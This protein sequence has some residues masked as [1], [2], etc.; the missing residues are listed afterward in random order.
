[1]TA[2]AATAPRRTAF[3]AL[4]ELPRR[5]AEG[6]LTVLATMAMVAVF[7]WSLI[8]ADWTPGK[9]G[10]SNFLP[11]VGMAGLAFGVLG[12]KVGWGRWRTHL[13]GALFGGIFI[14]LVV[15][16]IVV[17]TADWDIASLGARFEASANVVRL[18]YNDWVVLN[19]PFTSQT[20]HYHLIFG[21]LVWGAGM[22]AGFTIFGHHRPLDAVVVLG[23]AV[24][25]NM[26][27]TEH[28]QLYLMVIFTAAAL[29]VLIRT[30]VFEE[31]IT[32]ARR[33]IGDPATVGQLY[34]TGG[35]LFVVGAIVGSILLTLTASSAPLQGLWQDLPHSLQALSQALQK[36]APEGGDIRGLGVVGFGDNVT[37][38]GIWQ[39][40]D[41]TAFRAQLLT[42]VTAGQTFK[43]RAGT[44]AIYT[45]Y[46]WKWG[47]TRVEPTAAGGVLLGGDAAGDAP[48]TATRKEVT[49]RIT[50]DAF[51]DSTILG[52]NT[53]YTVNRPTNALVVGTGYFATVQATDGVGAYNVTARI[54]TF[55]DLPGGLTTPR[56]RLAGTD[57]PPGLLALYTA[58]PSGAMGP[59]AIKLLDTIRAQVHAPSYADPGN[60]YD[61]AHTMEGYLQSST[62]FQYDTNVVSER[63]AQCGSVSTVECFAIIHRGYCEY[64]AST[65][66]VL[67]RAF[68]VPARVAYGFLPVKPG[69]D[70][71]EVIQAKEAHWWVEVYFPG[72]GWV[73]FDPT[74]GGVGQPL[75]IPSGAIPSATPKVSHAPTTAGP[76]PSFPSGG[77]AGGVTPTSTGAGPFIAIALILLLGIGALAFAALRR[78][79]N[80]PMHPDKAWGSLASLA[81]RFGL[82]PKPSQTVYEYAGA[83]GDAVPGARVELTTIA[84]AKVEVAYG[85]RDLGVD[86]LKR[87]AEAYQRLRFAIL[88]VVVRRILRR[89]GRR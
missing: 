48:D 61:L 41:N 62:N 88:G 13:V 69:P 64:Y 39:P 20:A 54:P 81:T 24:I 78:A 16:G 53:L 52:P 8:D 2:I 34:L 25:A 5:P 46:G 51:R 23:L 33:K 44:Y 50:P 58:L 82:G 40:S 26:A 67:L 70:G 10:D 86:R 9:P 73:E 27:L 29:L 66:A 30:H 4:R 43:W 38:S 42:G 49:F 83:L 28:N 84:R 35:A 55:A 21:T 89:G 18:V 1:M 57:Y 7:G 72:T 68:G 17:P 74:G 79:P 80:K 87:I 45:D 76:G 77:G 59:N 12:A 56:L 14:P 3:D 15:G 6:W 71:V 36:F 63:N 22:L 19:L 11:W 47:D 60:A 75:A 65:M 31:E 85:Q 37:T 32:W